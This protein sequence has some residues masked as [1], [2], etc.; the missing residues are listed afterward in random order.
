VSSSVVGS[1]HQN[2]VFAGWMVDLDLGP[3]G[4]VV[5]VRGGP[6]RR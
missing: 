6:Q 4:D 3:A 2:S 5:I 1:D